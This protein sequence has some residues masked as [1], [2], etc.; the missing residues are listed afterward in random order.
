MRLASFIGIFLFCLSGYEL[1][2]QTNFYDPGIIPEI[3]IHF[4]EKNWRHILDSLFV[5]TGDEGKLKAE[6]IIDGNIYHDAGIRYKGY[7]SYN[8]NAI[9][10]PFNIDLD[11]CIKNQNHLGFTKIKLSNVIHDPSF[12]REV[13]AYE[14]ARN[15]M[16]ASRANFAMVYVNDTIMGLY[17]NVQAVDKI[18]LEE[19]FQSNDHSFFKGEPV[20]LIY[21]FGENSNLA[22]SH[23]NDSS[24]YIP[25]YKLESAAGWKDLFKLISLLNMGSDSVEN[26]LNVDRVL[27][28]NAFNQVLLNLD[29]YVGY[30][31][32]YYL[33]RDGQGRFSPILWDLNMSF[34]SFRESDGSYH[35]LGLNIEDLKQLDPLEHLSFSVS[36]RPLITKLISNPQLQKM[37]FAH[38]HTILID[39]IN[40]DLYYSRG[41][42]IQSLI[43]QLVLQDTNRFYSYQD[44]HN[45]LD[46]TVGGFAS[47]IKYPGLKDLMQARCTYLHNLPG[48]KNKPTINEITHFPEIPVKGETVWI[49][50]KITGAKNVTL[51][52]RFSHDDIFSKIE[53][54]DDGNHHDGEAG[55]QVYGAAII[56]PGPNIQ[57]Y[58]YAEN[59][60]SG[61]FSPE[62][63][64][65]EFY[66]LQTELMPG[67]IVIN[68]IGQDW[69]E[70]F[71]TTSETLNLCGIELSDG[72]MRTLTMAL[73]DT[74]ISPKGYLL[75]AK[76]ASACMSLWN[77]QGRLLDEVVFGQHIRGKTIG[78]Y[79]NGY[80]SMY[81]M[82]P[83]PYAHN[84]YGSVPESGFL[85]FP[86]PARNITYIEIRNMKCPLTISLSNILG[87]VILREEQPV[88]NETTAAIVRCLDLTSL[89]RGTYVVSIGNNEQIMTS[90]LIID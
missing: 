37:Y 29:S 81:Y 43:D 40:N 73:P 89:E 55:D 6:V 86:N 7:S 25:F 46:S 48:L 18:F 21:P 88:P 64:E 8:V 20:K 53:M 63:A 10:N 32:N 70:L 9:K 15:Y 74:L 49:N 22:F 77:R 69:V 38:I 72:L 31:Q 33:Y 80:G 30:A 47:M 11:Y 14:I 3:R 19:H 1:H 23:G 39:F 12:V 87:Q 78:R 62:R 24:D 50:T 61:S 26:M 34:G 54:A 5:H 16:P 75:I 66:N 42:T 51:G 44:F 76:T 71:N 57:Y 82:I 59:D 90:K 83:S 60:S 65:H 85:L 84:H 2:A 4:H 56:P 79:P 28:M 17:T 36:P 41:K 45:N 52:F 68:E 58:L 13:L 35:F 67:D 27:W